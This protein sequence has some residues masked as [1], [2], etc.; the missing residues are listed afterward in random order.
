MTLRCADL[1]GCLRAAGELP[2]SFPDSA[3]Y[4]GLL[5][6]RA[7]CE[8]WE[9]DN[10]IGCMRVYRI[11]LKVNH[12]SQGYPLYKVGAIGGDILSYNVAWRGMPCAEMFP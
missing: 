8:A 6:A 2:P 7:D 10:C 1:A 12:Q 5:P 11:G 9:I 4:S 3:P